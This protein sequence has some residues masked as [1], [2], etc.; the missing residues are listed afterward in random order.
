MESRSRSGH[1]LAPL[2]CPPD[3][4]F[5]Q[6]SSDE[7]E[8]SIVQAR[9]STNQAKVLLSAP[10][11]VHKKLKQPFK[12]AEVLS[13]D[14]FIQSVSVDQSRSL[15]RVRSQGLVK[16]K[17]VRPSPLLAAKAEALRREKEKTRR[18]EAAL[19]LQGWFRRHIQPVLLQ[20]TQALVG[21]VRHYGVH[22][23]VKVMQEVQTHLREQ[24][25]ALIA[26]YESICAELIQR[27]WK[28][29]KLRS[30][31]RAMRLRLQELLKALLQGW[32]TR[33]VL[34]SWMLEDCRNRIA[35]ASES[36]RRLACVE[37]AQVFT[38]E[39]RVGRWMRSRRTRPT[40]FLRRQKPAEMPPLRPTLPIRP[41]PPL[42]STPQLRKT[43]IETVGSSVTTRA[44][45]PHPRK[46]FLRR[47]SHKIESQKV[48]F[49]KVQTK[50]RCW[51][52]PK[53]LSG[54]ERKEAAL[55]FLKRNS[56]EEFVALE[57]LYLCGDL[58]QKL[59]IPQ[60]E[61]MRAASQPARSL[62][63]TLT[64]PK[65]FIGSASV[66]PPTAAPISIHRPE[67]KEMLPE[68]EDCD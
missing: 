36:E 13:F 48:D 50:V 43:E 32:K 54:L 35:T 38:E 6:L 56:V 1:S 27:A 18:R 25:T 68:D 55:R 58:K 37:L 39:Y 53:K 3:D 65:V 29:Y 9:K 11:S 8:T 24:Q 42:R 40:T 61:K 63:S 45:S 12:A 17:P 33:K 21:I 23:L 5:V 31:Y 67:A 66:R 51:T 22:C 59:P 26:R 46:A 30:F 41:T 28:R 34:K 7:E 52:Q 16:P 44:T 62:Y 60:S 15:T 57:R 4:D 10:P 49:S 20:R 2:Q 64:S 47:K 14:A 19:K